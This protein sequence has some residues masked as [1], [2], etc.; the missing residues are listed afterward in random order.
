[1]MTVEVH[2]C[3]DVTGFGFLG[4]A[5]EMIE[6]SDVGMTIHSSEMPFFAEAREY[7]E[8]GLLPGGLTRNREFRRCMV[9]LGPEVPQFMQDI[10]FDPQ[11]SGGLL[12][13]VP[14]NQAVSLVTRMHDEGI[15][16][17]AIVGEV[18]AEPKSRIVVR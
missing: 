2:A 3:T 12:I 9:E 17:A 7:A 13:S 15:K 11:T 1:M 6:G 10:L 16:K 8:K 18:V 14:G 5:C 4:H